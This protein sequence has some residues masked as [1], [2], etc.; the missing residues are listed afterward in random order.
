MRS[1]IEI[2]LKANGTL[3]EEITQG[4]DKIFKVLWVL[5]NIICRLQAE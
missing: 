5:L 2:E 4:E 3:F 1:K